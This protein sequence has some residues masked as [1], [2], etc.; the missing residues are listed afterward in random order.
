MEWFK[1]YVRDLSNQLLLAADDAAV[2]AWVRMLAHCYDLENGGRFAGCS[3]YSARQWLS[4]AGVDRKAVDRVVSAG[5]ATWEGDGLQVHGY[6]VDAQKK[7]TARSQQNRELANRRWGTSKGKAEAIAERNACCNAESG[8]EGN[9]KGITKGNAEGEGEKEGEED[10][11]SRAIP[12]A[13]A[14]EQGTAE[15]AAR[16]SERPAVKIRPTTGHNLVHC[17]KVALERQR[18]ERGPCFPGSFAYRDADELL[19]AIMRGG[20]GDQTDEIERRIALFVADD[21]MAPW[22]V[23]NF[24]NRYNGIGSARASPQPRVRGSIPEDYTP[25][26]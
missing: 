15:P 26:F 14:P 6:D 4:V 25:D 18:P 16:T 24:C 13:S 2:G 9:A 21:G 23:K 17:L 7:A 5:L 8:A 19:N 10:P 3:E 20:F 12:G 11:P 22:T 1:L